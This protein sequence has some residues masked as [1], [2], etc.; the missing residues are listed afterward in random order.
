M[1]RC[2][3]RRW[4]SDEAHVFPE[5][6]IGNEKGKDVAPG[7]VGEIIGRGENVRKGY[8]TM[9][10]ATA[11]ALRDGWLYTGDM[12]Y[13]DEEG[14]PFIVDRKKDIII[15]GGLNV[16]PREVEEV[17]QSHPAVA[18]AAVA[19]EREP[20]RGEVVKAFVRLK[21]GAEVNERE[22]IRYFWERLANY[23]VPRKI[24]FVQEM[25][26]NITGK[27]LKT[28]LRSME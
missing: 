19:G 4:W 17:L 25:P 9:A 21:E 3:S 14:Y 7:E 23:K 13:R 28:V 10:E 15:T 22:L 11:E 5:V 26:R 20:L 12:A 2:G 18:E 1:G 8:Y 27:V 16:Y 6:R 24:R